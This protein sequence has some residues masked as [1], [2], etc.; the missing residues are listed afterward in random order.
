MFG[1]QPETGNNSISANRF[2]MS[3]NDDNIS[4]LGLPDE[5]L[6]MLANIKDSKKKVVLSSPDDSIDHLSQMGIPDEVMQLLHD[7]KTPKEVK[8]ETPKVEEELFIPKLNFN[9]ESGFTMSADMLAKLNLIQQN[10]DMIKENTIIPSPPSP[11]E[12]E[13]NFPMESVSSINISVT[14]NYTPQEAT[15]LV[16]SFNINEEGLFLGIIIGATTKTTA[17]E[18]I[19]QYSTTKWQENT[20]ESILAYDDISVTLYFDDDIVSQL[21]FGKGFRGHTSKGLKIGD[22]M[23]TAVEIYGAPRMKSPRGAVWDKIKVFISDGY[24]TSIKIQK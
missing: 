5:A 16:K 3:E 19:S 15:S 9:P 24:I 23:E 8:K 7:M 4:S 18:I 11:P 17:M 13:V 2:V 12:E 20:N 6:R 22:T 21:E 14:N 10:T 1:N